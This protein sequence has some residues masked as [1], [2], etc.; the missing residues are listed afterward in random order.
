MY[1]D[2]ADHRGSVMSRY[3]LGQVLRALDRPADTLD[4]PAIELEVQ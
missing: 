3:R 1:E 4:V 2:L